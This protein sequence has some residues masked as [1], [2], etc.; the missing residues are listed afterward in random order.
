VVNSG[1]DQMAK[2][3]A[4]E[5]NR[6]YNQA[7]VSVSDYAVQQVSIPG[8]TTPDFLVQGKMTRS[9]TLGQLHQVLVDNGARPDAIHILLAHDVNVTGD[10][11]AKGFSMGL[12]GPLDADRSNA[13][14]LV[15]THSFI[16]ISG[17]IAVPGLAVTVAHEGGHFLG[18]Y[19]TTEEDHS[20]SDPIPDTPTCNNDGCPD[21]DNIMFWVGQTNTNRQILTPG[22]SEV[23]RNH[24]LCVPSQAPQMVDVQKCTTV[25]N[26]PGTTCVFWQGQQA[27]MP[28]CDPAGDPCKSGQCQA[29]DDGTFVCGN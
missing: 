18:L 8:L 10:E 6:L 12:P 25:C 24:P 9:E 13:V 1:L 5:V 2:N 15:G 28:A 29:G 16:D 20:L 19:H 23:M 26:D 3:L 27:C 4:Q 22:Q 14:V 21:Q 7:N 17:N 11:M